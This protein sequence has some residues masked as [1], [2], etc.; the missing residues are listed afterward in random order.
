MRGV[1]TTGSVAAYL[2]AAS[3]TPSIGTNT[4]GTAIETS[5]DRRLSAGGFSTAG[6]LA[7]GT[8]AA[9]TTVIDGA[10]AGI[11]DSNSSSQHAGTSGSTDDERA[12]SGVAIAT[13]LSNNWTEWSAPLTL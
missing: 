6:G 9:G 7:S 2:T 11:S 4:T 3:A 1:E 8:A 10:A 5:L 13:A 12:G